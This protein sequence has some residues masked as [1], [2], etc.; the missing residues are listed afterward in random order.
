MNKVSTALMDFKD[1]Q[2]DLEAL[3]W[4]GRK[5]KKETK[6]IIFIKNAIIFLILIMDAV[7][8]NVFERQSNWMG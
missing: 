6:A 1:H 8:R 3:D 5:V 2:A 4:M 7:R